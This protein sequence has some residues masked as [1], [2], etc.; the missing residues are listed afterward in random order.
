MSGQSPIRYLAVT[1]HDGSKFLLRVAK[2]TSRTLRGTEVD[3]DGE[4]VTGK[5]FDVR[6]RIVEIG[7]I[8]KAVEMR[9]NVT[10]GRIEKLR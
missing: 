9:M 7:A 2:E 4:E 6:E 8:E 3:K 1:L 10:Y 5:D